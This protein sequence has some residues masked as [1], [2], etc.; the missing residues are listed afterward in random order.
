VVSQGTRTWQLSWRDQAAP[1]LL[2]GVAGHAGSRMPG[3][4]SGG[5][6]AVLGL[7][8]H[9]TGWPIPIG[10]SRAI[11]AAL[12]HDLT[13]HGG[14]IE[15][16]HR[17]TAFRR[18]PAARA[19]LFDTDLSGMASILGKHN[20][21]PRRRTA[22]VG[23]AKVDFELSGP[24]PWADP[25]LAQ[26]STIHL[27][28]SHPELTE[29]ERSLRSGAG[30]HGLILASDPACFDPSRIVAGRR[31]FWT[32]AHVA[33]GSAEDVGAAVQREI[34]RAAPGFGDLVLA[35]RTIP[36][37]R[38]PDHNANYRGGDIADG[39]RSWADY[40]FGTG[41]RLNPYTT[42]RDDMFCCSAGT[43]PGPGVHGIGGHCAALTV[44]RKRF[45]IR[46]DPDLSP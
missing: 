42:W 1:A 30:G 37:A 19:Y 6:L 44:L 4:V 20:R 21:Q 38:M 12:E 34:E 41:R 40:I 26:A 27:G 36:A 46:E 39:F 28:G 8:A 7:L 11:T 32:Y 33:Y 24:V 29:K 16:G 45:G 43:P 5:T 10:G 2:T 3:I 14:T 9:R 22:G 25:E 15:T 35:R 23:V 18:L 17:V 31:P 13:I